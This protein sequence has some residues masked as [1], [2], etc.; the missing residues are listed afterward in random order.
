METQEISELDKYS[1][2]TVSLDQPIQSS[3][4]GQFIEIV[5]DKDAEEPDNEYCTQEMIN[6]LYMVMKTLSP[7]EC[8]VLKMYFG[9]QQSHAM[10]L[11]EIAQYF[12]VTRERI[13]Q[14]KEKALLRL[15]YKSRCR[16]LR[17]EFD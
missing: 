6:E 10:T 1:M 8:Q 15:R 7:K 11:D 3:E 13:R 4:K 12:K 9:I 5:E 14:I 17:Y 16:S 2:H